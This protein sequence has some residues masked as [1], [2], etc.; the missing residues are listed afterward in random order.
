[1]SLKF[2]NNTIVPATFIKD[3]G[4]TI[5]HNLTYSKHISQLTSKCM[6][7][8]CQINPVK[9][10]FDPNTFTYII[11]AVVMGKLYYG[12]TVWSNTSAANIRKLQVVQKFACRIIANGKEFDHITLFLRNT[13]WLPV[14]VHLLCRDLV[15]MIYKCMNGLTPRYFVF[16]CLLRL[17]LQIIVKMLNSR[18]PF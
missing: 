2:L 12:S 16:V 5:D 17:V 6:A 1:M 8:L 3:L 9:H 4:I 14:K 11:C 18:L 15:V 10:C 13:G 7:K